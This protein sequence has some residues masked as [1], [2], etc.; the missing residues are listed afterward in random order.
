MMFHC[1]EGCDFKRCGWDCLNWSCQFNQEKKR[2]LKMSDTEKACESLC[3][4]I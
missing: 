3:F 2:E 1:P 4:A